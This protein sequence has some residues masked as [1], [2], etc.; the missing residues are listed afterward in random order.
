MTNKKSFPY[1][2][3]CRPA[4]FSE[5]WTLERLPFCISKFG[6]LKING[7]SNRAEGPH[8]SCTGHLTA[9]PGHCMCMRGDVAVARSPP[10]HANRQPP[11]LWVPCR[12]H[13]RRRCCPYPLHRCREKQFPLSPIHRPAPCRAAP[14]RARCSTTYF[15]TSSHRCGRSVRLGGSPL[16]PPSSCCSG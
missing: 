5:F 3:K 13:V 6:R 2:S 4:N 16:E 14:L 9:C 12:L 10:L 7:N 15:H 11:P 1:V 8:V